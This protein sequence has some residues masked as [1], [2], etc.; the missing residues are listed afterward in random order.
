MWTW[1]TII[2]F[3]DIFHLTIYSLYYISNQPF[4]TTFKH[5]Y[6][7]ISQGNGKFLAYTPC[8]KCHVQNKLTGLSRV[9]V[10]ISLLVCDINLLIAPVANVL[11]KL[12]GQDKETE[13]FSRPAD[14]GEIFKGKVTFFQPGNYHCEKPYLCLVTY[15]YSDKQVLRRIPKF[16]AS[17]GCAQ[18][19]T[20]SILL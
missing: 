16:Y 20:L 15:S 4:S 8:L 13:D 2:R 18:N 1:K 12:G 7:I 14:L 3:V 6:K 19:Y 9:Y 11:A 10:G 5:Q 17:L